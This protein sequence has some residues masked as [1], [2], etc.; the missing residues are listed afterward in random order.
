MNILEDEYLEI[1]GNDA[2]IYKTVV[3]KIETTIFNNS[4]CD[5]TNA[6]SFPDGMGV[7]KDCGENLDKT[8]LSAC[9]HENTFEDGNGLFICKKCHTE[10]ENFDFTP[11][12]SFYRDK[13]FSFSKDPARCHRTY[14]PGRGLE[15]VFE[16]HKINIPEAIRTQVEMKYDKIVGPKTVRG[17]G[18]K[19]IIAACLFHA[20]Q[21]FGQFRTSDYVRNLFKLSKKNM[22]NGLSEY[23]KI[24]P[25]ARTQHTRPEDLLRWILILTNINQSH[26]RKIVQISRY[27]ENSS[28]LLKRS[29]P[30]SVASAIV[31]FYL[32]LNPTYK[33]QL[34][35]TK[36]KFAEQALLSDITVTKLVKEAANISQCMVTM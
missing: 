31:Y 12:W 13:D 22:S 29:S 19:A 33:N 3:N 11:E 15:K 34:G 32:C 20:Y 26:Y 35:L 4:E 21:E 6:L 30:Q 16:E 23:Y 17:K 5:H 14:F 28:S 1:F 9:D 10:F 25:L 24:Y 7:C 8:Q 18:R 27:L 2:T 36:N